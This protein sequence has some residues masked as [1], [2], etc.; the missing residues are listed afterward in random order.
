MAISSRGIIIKLQ[1][2]VHHESFSFWRRRDNV[3]PRWVVSKKI[4][5]VI[6]VRDLWA[7]PPRCQ[8]A[9][10]QETAPAS[11]AKQS[12]H[13]RHASWSSWRKAMKRICCLIILVLMCVILCD[14]HRRSR[15]HYRNTLMRMHYHSWSFTDVLDTVFHLITQFLAPTDVA[16]SRKF[17]FLLDPNNNGTDNFLGLNVSQ[18]NVA[19]VSLEKNL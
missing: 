17:F 9:R 7:P 4:H 3:S 8:K 2:K 1:I 16:Q 5:L 18:R 12:W 6:L 11:V 19:Y 14:G 13:S 10:N 15:R